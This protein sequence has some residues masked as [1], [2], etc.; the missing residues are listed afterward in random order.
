MSFTRHV[1]SF[2]RRYA[3]VE[4]SR[5]TDVNLMMPKPCVRVDSAA[6]LCN[7][8]EGRK[9]MMSSNLIPRHLQGSFIKKKKLDERSQKLK[10]VRTL[11]ID[12][13][14]S[15][16]Y[17]IYQELSVINGGKLSLSLNV[18][19]NGFHSF[20]LKI[21]L[22]CFLLLYNGVLQIIIN[23]NIVLIFVLFLFFFCG[24]SPS[25]RAKWWMDLERCLPLLVQRK[26]IW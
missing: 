16:T 3:Y 6:F 20:G 13:Y 4:G 2:D 7:H 26:G 24:S 14:D 9:V 17:N 11:L 23:W 1:P 5:Y 18:Q 19:L 21:L 22:L 12:N 25:G 10:L 15:Y 8:R